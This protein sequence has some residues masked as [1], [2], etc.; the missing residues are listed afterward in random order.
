[1]PTLTEFGIPS[2]RTEVF[3]PLCKKAFQSTGWRSDGLPVSFECPA[4]R[5]PK[6]TPKA[7]LPGSLRKAKFNHVKRCRRLDFQNG[8]LPKSLYFRCIATVMPTKFRSAGS[9]DDE[10]RELSRRRRAD[11]QKLYRKHHR[12]KTRALRHTE[13]VMSEGRESQDYCSSSVR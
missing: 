9:C 11:L 13:Q 2:E 1:M 12:A 4:D 8:I 5:Y 6:T 3:C 7:S 10:R